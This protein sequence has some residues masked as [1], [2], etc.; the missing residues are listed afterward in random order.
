MSLS[1]TE[2]EPFLRQRFPDLE[3]MVKIEIGRLAVEFQN[4]STRFDEDVEKILSAG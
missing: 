3:E 4:K 1:D 2:L